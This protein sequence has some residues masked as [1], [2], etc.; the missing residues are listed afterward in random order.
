MICNY[1]PV[2]SNLRDFHKNTFPFKELLKD[3][4]KFADNWYKNFMESKK[5]P[6]IEDIKEKAPNDR[7]LLEKMTVS[8]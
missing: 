6:R 5:L 7:C 2:V 3:P 8:I 4:E 1:E